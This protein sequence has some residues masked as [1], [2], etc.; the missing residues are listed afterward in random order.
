MK[1]IVIGAGSIGRRHHDN[2]VHMGVD[3]HLVPWRAYRPEVLDGADA[4]VIATA[5]DVRLAP[6]RDAAERGLP[7]YIE[8]PMAFR[9]DDLDQITALMAPVADRSMLGLMMRY[10]PAFRVLADLDLTETVRFSCDIGHD[11]TQWRANRRFSDSYAARAD[12]GGVLLD[13]CHEI[14]MAAVLFP[15]LTLGPVSCLGHPAYPGVDMSSRLML[16][17]ANGAAGSVGMDYL[18]PKLH[19][20]TIVYGTRTMA[21][22]D[23]A[24]QRY[25]VTDAQGARDIP[26]TMER[27]EMFVGITRDWLALL[28]G[29][30]ASNP[31]VPRLDRVDEST[32]L[33]AA[34][35]A[36]RHFTGHIT[37][38]IP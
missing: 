30:G 23:F 34:A 19:R 26:I 20:R 3:S 36:G 35:W 1:I 11:V 25:T 14:D 17:A 37:K 29:Q 5:T 22:F 9:P 13:L 18:T 8:K 24:A 27:N 33:T 10:H 4:A 38:E 7:L 12:G 2:L 31:L 6:I 16:T 21:D 32:R 15:G 28:Q